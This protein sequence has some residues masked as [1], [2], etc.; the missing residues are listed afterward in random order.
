L[1]IVLITSAFGLLTIPFWLQIGLRWIV[2]N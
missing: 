1:R 2:P